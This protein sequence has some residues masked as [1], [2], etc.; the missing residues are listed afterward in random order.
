MSSPSTT[1]RFTFAE[2]LAALVI[3]A[4]VLPIA[5]RG[6]LLANR[7]SLV[8]RRSEQAARI[9][10]M[11]LNELVVTGDWATTGGTGDFE[12]WPGYT[13]ELVSDDWSEDEDGTTGMTQLTVTV[14]FAVQNRELSVAQT[15][16]V[17]AEEQ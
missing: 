7:Q 1:R 16:L 8:A 10:S 4:L 14:C 2:A 3:A 15:T 12:D 17:G 6:V 5:V 11:W 9:G 13:W